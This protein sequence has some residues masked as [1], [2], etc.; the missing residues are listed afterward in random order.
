MLRAILNKSWKQHPIIKQLYGY[1]PTISKTIQIIWI[2]DF[3]ILETGTRHTGHC[4]RSKDELVRQWIPSHEP[5]GVGR[6]ARTYLQ[7]LFTDTGF[8][9][10]DLPNA[11]DHRYEWRGRVR[12]IRA[13]CKGYKKSETS[14]SVGMIPI[15]CPDTKE[16]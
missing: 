9:P 14:S 3:E 12:E 13:V 15:G 1:F 8:S 16:I 4:W 10:D 7:Q 5:A 11:M 2:W 6:P